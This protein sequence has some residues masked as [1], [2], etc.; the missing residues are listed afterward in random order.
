MKTRSFQPAPVRPSVSSG[1][2]RVPVAT[3]TYSGHAPEVA[4]LVNGHNA[5]VTADSLRAYV[6]AAREVLSK[7]ERLVAL[8]A[9]CAASAATVSID[10]MVDRFATGIVESVA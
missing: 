4:Y 2:S 3:T 5:I 10:S 7:P 8:R 1:C 9:G 6:G